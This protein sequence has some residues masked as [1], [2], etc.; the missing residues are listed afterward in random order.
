[1]RIEFV[2]HASFIIEAAGIKL[3]TDPWLEGTAFHDGWALVE[4][5]HFAWERFRE[6]THIW[7]SHEHPDHFSPPNLKQIPEAYRKNICILFHQTKDRKVVEYCRAIGF[8]NV[9]ELGTGWEAISADFKV[10]N[11]P[12]TDGDSWLC[13]KTEGKCLLNV[14][15]CNLETDAEVNQIKAAISCNPDVLF[16]QFSYANSIGNRSDTALRAKFARAKIEEV[17]RQIRILKP[18]YVVPFASFVWFCHEENFFRNDAINTVLTAMKAIEKTAAMPVILFNADQWEP[19]QKHD[20]L[21][22][23]LSWQESYAAQIKPENVKKARTVGLDELKQV[24]HAFCTR[25]L[26]KNSLLIRFWL[27]PTHIYV[28]DLDLTLCLSLD[29]LTQSQKSSAHCD[30]SLGSE[31]LHY[32]FK[33]EWGGSTTRINGRYEVPLSGKFSRFKRYFLISQF[34]NQGETLDLSYAVNIAKTK[35]QQLLSKPA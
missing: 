19:G 10:M 23:A 31:V 24:A 16:T 26:D 28:K 35:T 32:C 17:H 14:N 12:H 33:F 29:G 2:N 13:V 6:I 11:R 21:A 4:P 3:I 9:R 7:F 30:V 18:S 34:N 20:S 25:L 22:S 1:M 8:E 15:D 27:E 5:S